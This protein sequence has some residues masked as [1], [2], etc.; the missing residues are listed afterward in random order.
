MKL[1]TF[2]TTKPPAATIWKTLMEAD[3]QPSD[4]L[5]VMHIRYLIFHYFRTA[6][7]F[8]SAKNHIN[9]ILSAPQI[10]GSWANCNIVLSDLRKVITDIPDHLPNWVG[11]NLYVPYYMAKQLGHSRKFDR[12]TITDIEDTH[13]DIDAND[14]DPRY[15]A[16][17]IWRYCPEMM[18]FFQIDMSLSPITVADRDHLIAILRSE[19]DTKLKDN[20]GI[21]SVEDKITIPPFTLGG[22]D[23]A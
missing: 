16:Y 9:S 1:F 4:G 23:E 8:V 3:I 5:S 14:D 19:I 21:I 12:E 2:A 7:S 17:S 15:T 13:L 22:S 18:Q 6:D 10:P 11:D 20:D